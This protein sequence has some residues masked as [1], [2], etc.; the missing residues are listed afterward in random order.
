MNIFLQIFLYVDVFIIGVA[1]TLAIRHGKEHLRVKKSLRSDRSVHHQQETFM[2][3]ELKQQLIEESEEEYRKILERSSTRL[4]KELDETVERINLS[5]K[6]MSAD[7][8]TKE[9]KSYE[10]LFEQYKNNALEEFDSSK[11]QTSNYQN[12]LK[13]KLLEDIEKEKERLFALIDNK[14]S[15]AVMAFLLEAMQH[16]VDL[17]AQ[18]DYLLKLLEEH[19]EEFKQ[20]LGS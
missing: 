20:A 19:K 18:S 17:G 12:E 7:V 8:V 15:D 3:K 11:E 1:A 2:P 4:S 14:L 6:K 13:A 9:L 16:E 5:V 10:H